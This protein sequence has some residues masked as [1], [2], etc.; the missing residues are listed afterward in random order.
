MKPS[1]IFH[2]LIFFI[3]SLLLETS[4]LAIPHFPAHT[5]HPVK[6]T[7]HLNAFN[8]T[9]FIGENGTKV[10]EPSRRSWN[11][12]ATVTPL[13]PRD[14]PPF[15]FTEAMQ[16]YQHKHHGNDSHIIYS[17]ELDKAPMTLPECTLKHY[18]NASHHGSPSDCEKSLESVKRWFHD[19]PLSSPP[20]PL[21][22]VSFPPGPMI[23]PKLRRPPVPQQNESDRNGV[24][25]PWK[26]GDSLIVP[27]LFPPPMNN[28]VAKRNVTTS[29]TPSTNSISET[30]PNAESVSRGG[31][32]NFRNV[33]VP[34]QKHGTT[35]VIETE[36]QPVRKLENLPTRNWLKTGTENEIFPVHIRRKP[37]PFIFS[38]SHLSKIPPQNTQNQNYEQDTARDKKATMP[39]RNFDALFI[40]I[41]NFLVFYVGKSFAQ[42]VP[43]VIIPFA[44]Y[45]PT[46]HGSTSSSPSS[47]GGNLI[48]PIAACAA[49][50]AAFLPLL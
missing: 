34:S 46:Y 29:T 38:N 16:E 35:F 19:K 11:A 18:G 2:P 21:H 44:P 31:Q 24:D 3:P 27:D 45:Q 48:S 5:Y 40:I 28:T 8:E 4:A 36:K 42:P 30:N 33:I 41:V 17:S 32:K 14:D 43:A 50:I 23:P 15:D 39:L 20:S 37:R 49:L 47:T 10:L 6:H 25:N 13:V 26:H 22:H 12:T 1:T 7:S 9:I